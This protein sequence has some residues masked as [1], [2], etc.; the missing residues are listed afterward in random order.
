MPIMLKKC[1]NRQCNERI[2]FGT[3][4]CN[5][6]RRESAR[7]QSY[8]RQSSNKRGYDSQWATIRAGYLSQ[9][10]LCEGCLREGRTEAATLVHHIIELPEGSNDDDNLMSL[11]VNCHAKQHSTSGYAATQAYVPTK[12]R[13]GYE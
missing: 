13:S 3:A 11:C 1:A 4:F 2:P 9:N 12:A 5:D 6:H 8:S 7:I 10:P